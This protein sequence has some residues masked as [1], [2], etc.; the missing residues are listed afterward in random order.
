MS[1]EF[2]AL[3]QEIEKLPL[4]QIGEFVKYLEERWGVTAAAP[5]AAMPMMMP[6]MAG[7]AAEAEV[8]QTEFDV[9]LAEV[10]AE[11]VKVIK[12]VREVNPGLGLK[13]AKEVVESAP[14]PILQAVTKE[15]AQR[16]KGILEE[17]GAKITIK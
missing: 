9:V 10:G 6:G 8:E 7:P 17:A 3:A 13:E 12:A 11:K 4:P 1:A 14:A 2:E 15:D 5:M 16:A